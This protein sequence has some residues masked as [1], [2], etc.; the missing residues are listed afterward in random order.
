MSNHIAN[1]I[2]KEIEA[3]KQ[4]GIETYGEALTAFNKRDST[5]DALEE[6][7]DLA[8][9][10]KQWQIE[11]QEMVSFIIDIFWSGLDSP[12]VDEAEELLKKLGEL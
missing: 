5:Q 3:R 1:L 10:I 2:I 8:H 6:A 12:W 7:L 11:R 9:Y 4:K